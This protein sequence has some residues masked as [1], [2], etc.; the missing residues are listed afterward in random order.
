MALG[1][2]LSG[3][4]AASKQMDV[5][6]NN[7]A[8]VNSTGFKQSRAEFADV[9]ASAQ[10]TSGQ[11]IGSGVRLASVNQNFTQGTVEFTGNA[12]DVAINGDGFFVMSDGGTQTYTRNGQF[13][14]DK[15]GFIVNSQGLLV[16]GFGAD[17]SG[18]I[19][20]AI[21][22]MT[23]PTGDNQPSASTEVKMG[24]NLNAQDTTPASSPFDPLDPDTYTRATSLTVYDSL[25][26]SHVATTYYVKT[27]TANEWKMHFALDGNEIDMDSAD[28]DGDGDT[29][30]RLLVFDG[31]GAITTPATPYLITAATIPTGTLGSGASA[32]D[33]NFDVG[34]LTQYGSPFSVDELSQ[35]G[36]TTGRLT[37]VDISSEG[38]LF[39][40]Y[41]NGQS[42]SVGQIALANF[43]N[44]QGLSQLGD[45]TWAETFE[46][47]AALV[48]TPGS[49]SMGQ[50]QGGGLEN[51]NVDLTEMLVKLITA[52]RNFQANAKTIETE[53]A[54]TQTI[55]NL[56]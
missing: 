23:V 18:A 14:V 13:H 20:G 30:G 8:N 10:F 1:I 28:S 56:R 19:T 4:N 24:L 42:T 47:G 49:S 37:S 55:I 25:G 16:Q 38:V 2:A 36:F 17:S 5:I 21:T 6:G 43:S 33:L 35:D 53:S 11:A 40:R 32:L 7:I 41:D 27:A 45:T 12:L 46:S 39:A 44:V 51:A 29:A 31:S 26:A 34:S 54:I 22:D 52:Q 9:F 15:D 50:L 48:G 3:L